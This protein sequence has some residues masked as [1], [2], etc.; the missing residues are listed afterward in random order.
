MPEGTPILAAVDGVVAEA[1]E[2]SDQGTF[3]V[4]CVFVC[5]CAASCLTCLGGPD[6]AMM[7]F[8]NYVIVQHADLS[9]AK[10]VHLRKAGV[11]AKE[12]QHVKV[13]TADN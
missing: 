2:D 7:S 9:L 10:Y 13:S 3:D 5:V 1:K 11:V 6:K 4:L 12:G 8:A